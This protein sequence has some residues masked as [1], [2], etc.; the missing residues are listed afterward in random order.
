MSSCGA[1]ADS[2]KLT[3]MFPIQY[4]DDMQKSF[5]KYCVLRRTFYVYLHVRLLNHPLIKT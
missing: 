4:S 5:N 2:S 1:F 3:H